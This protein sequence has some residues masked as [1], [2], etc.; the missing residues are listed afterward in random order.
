MVA[1]ST[2]DICRC[3]T[4]TT[5]SAFWR[6]LSGLMRWEPRACDRD[7]LA[8]LFAAVIR[9][10]L[11]LMTVIVEGVLLAVAAALMWLT[12]LRPAMSSTSTDLALGLL[13]GCA[14]AVLAV[15]VTRLP[16]GFL[17]QLQRD[18]HRVIAF[19]KGFTVLDFAVVALLA[20]V[21]EEALFRGALLTW[22]E[23]PLGLHG[24]VLLSALL[25]G[26]A[27]AISPSYVVFAFVMGAALG[28][29]YVLTGSL[30]A[31]M[32]AHATY[33]LVALVYGTRML[34]R[35]SS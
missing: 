30:P 5:T 31:A 26:L 27:H 7:A 16:V 33:D 32:A 1:R 14:M 11:L 10:S 34:A 18:I 6:S 8:G 35:S 29:L 2:S 13:A 28:Y 9:R 4:A 20:G 24:A 21:C 17:G 3:E 12:G 25:F 23:G 22:L 19:F 15:I